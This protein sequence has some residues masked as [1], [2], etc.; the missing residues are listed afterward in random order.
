MKIK[1][2]GR[3]SGR[4]SATVVLTTVAILSLVLVGGTY[5]RMQ[6]ARERT[7][8]RNLR[9]L[10]RIG[11]AVEGQ[12]DNL[13][14][15]LSGIAKQ[16]LV[17]HEGLDSQVVDSLIDAEANRKAALVQGLGE[18]HVGRSVFYQGGSGPA[19]GGGPARASTPDAGG[20]DA[21]AAPSTPTTHKL[22]HDAPRTARWPTHR[23]RNGNCTR[24]SSLSAA[25]ISSWCRGT[26]C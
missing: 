24:R 25:P 2:G 10:E 19:A 5:L 20:A 4:G 17:S 8:E 23:A 18:M 7:T 13:S 9:E 22:R 6:T 1:R 11:R 16:S 15:V 14:S 3:P 21:G 26:P 12:V